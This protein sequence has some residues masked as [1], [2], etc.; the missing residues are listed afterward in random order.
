MPV[1][2]PTLL[3]PEVAVLALSVGA[4]RGPLGATITAAVAFA[5]TLGALLAWPPSR[6]H[7]LA[8]LAVSAVA[9]VVAIDLIIDG[10]LDI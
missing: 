8:A 5:A 2:V 1:A 10:V 4:D 9:V 7:R 6:W 3:R